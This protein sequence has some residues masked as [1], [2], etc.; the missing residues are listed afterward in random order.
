MDRKWESA[1]MKEEG[2][3]LCECE[4]GYIN[5]ALYPFSGSCFLPQPVNRI[6]LYNSNS[7]LIHTFTYTPITMD[8]LSGIASKLGGKGDSH[9]QGGSSG[10]GSGQQE[11]YL[12]KG[13]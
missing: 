1:K 10:S 6:Y 13:V 4:E 8:K 9:H 3:K 12:D 5:P 7:F 2:R 11:D